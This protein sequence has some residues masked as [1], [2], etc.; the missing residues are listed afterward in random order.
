MIAA[1]APSLNLWKN[2]SEQGLVNEH[3]GLVPVGSVMDLIQRSPVL[4]GNAINY[5]PGEEGQHHF[6]YA[7]K[8]QRSDTGNEERMQK[9]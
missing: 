3:G 1:A 9:A 5:I 6:P 4:I 8:Q 2:L 7:K